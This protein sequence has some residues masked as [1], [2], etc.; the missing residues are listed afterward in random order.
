[1]ISTVMANNLGT[2]L[3]TNNF[4]EDKKRIIDPKEQGSDEQFD[5]S[6]RPKNLSEYV[7]Q[8][9]IK[10]NLEI[11]I[12]AAKHRQEAV[13]HV[14]LYGAPGLGKNYFSPCHSQRNRGTH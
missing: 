6:L 11:A 4:M 5:F 7:G 14:L 10:A 8:E 13:E 12:K 3:V 2:S 1:M 9:K